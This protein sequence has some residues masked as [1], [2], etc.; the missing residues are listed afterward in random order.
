ML[1]AQFPAPLNLHSFL[2]AA[3]WVLVAQFLA[4]LGC[5]VLAGMGI[6][7]LSGV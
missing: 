7:S 1:V 2:R 6:F 5:P 3:R 4:R